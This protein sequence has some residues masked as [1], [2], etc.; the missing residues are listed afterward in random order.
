MS[1][2]VYGTQTMGQ[3]DFGKKIQ[4]CRSMG[5]MKVGK[6]LKFY[7]KLGKSIIKYIVYCD[8]GWLHLEMGLV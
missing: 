2:N 1:K 3:V 7:L 6:V 8:A 4:P 5:S